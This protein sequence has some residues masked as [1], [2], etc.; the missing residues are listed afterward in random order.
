M[1]EDKELT[2]TISLSQ[3]IRILIFVYSVEPASYKD[4]KE[5]ENILRIAGHGRMQ[6][7]ADILCCA[8][9]DMKNA[10]QIVSGLIMKVKR[11]VVSNKDLLDSLK[12]VEKII[13]QSA[14]E[15]EDA[16]DV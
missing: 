12:R 16:V 9:H 8:A 11:G 6:A 5:K 1:T 3:Y 13:G 4:I 2:I 15:Y 10:Q 14:E 7:D